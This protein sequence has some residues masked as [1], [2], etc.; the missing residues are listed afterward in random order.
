MLALIEDAWS[1]RDW[2]HRVGYSVAWHEDLMKVVEVLGAVAVVVVKAVA[3]KMRIT[4]VIVKVEDSF[5]VA[6][7]FRNVRNVVSL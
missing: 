6:M 5:V 1:A 4:N 3:A 2:K 7:S